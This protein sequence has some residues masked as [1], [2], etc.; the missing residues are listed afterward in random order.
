MIVLSNFV[1]LTL[2]FANILL[3]IIIPANHNI[4]GFLELLYAI[5]VF[6][7]PVFFNRLHLTG[8]SRMYECWLPPILIIWFMS[9]NMREAEYITISTY[10]GLRYYLLCTSC[11]P[12]LIFERKNPVLLIA[13]VLP[14]FIAIFFCDSILDLMGVGYDQKGTLDE[15]YGFTTIRSSI[16]YI[17][18]N[19]IC[20][21]LR[22]IVDQG[23]ALNEKLFSE[24][25]EKNKLD[26]EQAEEKLRHSESKYRSLFE[27]ASD[28]IAVSDLNGNFTDC[29]LKASQLLGY[30][31][32]EL[33]RLNVTEIMD[34]EQILEHPIRFDLL[35]QGQTLFSER[36]LLRK[37]GTWLEIE[38]SVKKFDERSLLAIMRDVSQRK[39]MEQELREAESKFR[40]LVEQSL[41]G[42]YIIVEG[43][44]AYV[45]PQFAEIL[46]YDRDEIL[47]ASS[48][49][50]V[51]HPDDRATVRENLRARLQGEK[52]SVRY[53]LRGIKKNGEI[54]WAEAFG[55][56]T[57]YLGGPAI[58]GTLIDITE[59]KKFEDEHAL[60]TLLVNSSEDAII[61]Q[62]L[63]G[64]IMS[65]NRGANKLFGYEPDE[66][67]GKNVAV[68]IPADHLREEAHIFE[69]V[70]S[71]K[72]VENFETQRKKKDGTK[73]DISLT[74]SPVRDTKGAI[75]G[76]SR[77]ARDITAR[78]RVEEE[79]DRTRH[80]LNERIKE[81]RLL[82]NANQIL[83]TENK[84][85]DV[86]LQEIAMILPL[87]WQYPDTSAAR[88]ILGNQQFQT[89]YF[90]KGV[91]MQSAEFS[92]QHGLQG[93]IELIYL[94]EHPQQDE[95]P[96]LRE[97]RD[98]INMLAE[99]IR[100]YL[101]R[102]HEAD[103]LKKSEANLNSTINNTTFFI[104]SVNKQLELKSINNTFQKFIKDEFGVKL[105]EGQSI[106]ELHKSRAGLEEFL[107]GWSGFYERALRGESFGLE[108]E[109]L[110]RSFKF[111]FNPIVEGESVAGVSV[112]SEE[113][114]ALKG[115]EKEL[116]D[117]NKQIND[118]KLMALRAAMNPHFIFNTLN[119]IQYYIMESDQRTALVYLSTFSKLIR[120]MLNNSVLSKIKLSEEL[121]MLRHYIVLE[122]MRF[123]N[124]FDFTM[125][126]APNIDVDNIEIPSMLIQP[127]VENAILHGINNKPG[128][129][130]L[131]I[132]VE[133]SS[134]SILFELEDDGVGRVASQR[135]REQDFNRHKSFGTTLTEERLKLINTRRNVSHEII[136]LEQD[137]IPIGTRVK[138]WVGD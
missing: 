38:T 61:S 75:V 123:E 47:N 33:V 55:S 81:L 48:M 68:L 113:T 108:G 88:I 120:G 20:L 110:G 22:V 94:T 96:F 26:Q 2:V 105:K 59:R 25:A 71:G 85:V 18:I 77:I 86:A 74:A 130:T 128:R 135:L 73:V 6:S 30:S 57:Q 69:M 72:A 53:E 119:S 4:Y 52:E 62:T 43:K 24:L 31:R 13:G 97:E 79:K 124:K 64:K 87:G 23:D 84:P 11:I 101:T 92:T 134:D 29:N 15:G 60:F 100:I 12:Y 118:L 45:N 3:F 104:W 8:L 39:R 126:V 56:F 7:L 122:Q 63:D 76:V 42:V 80:L 125:Q 10:D 9:I 90:N 127:Y 93:R 41:V 21:S 28:A 5:V 98:L 103:A 46:G 132:S 129:G 36:K 70:R 37:D 51:V 44:F 27:Q 65:W 83:Q 82:Y 112:F 117:A 16:S 14:G 89:A 1:A 133:E 49:E 19:G 78:K 99:M 114:T 54:L 107:P 17:V 32:E 58:I 91:N 136:D 116:F 106:V 109:Y 66:I 137:G 111:S 95:G 102:K 115:K 34:K 131:K 138:I 50:F 121:E 40:N 67:I 35:Q